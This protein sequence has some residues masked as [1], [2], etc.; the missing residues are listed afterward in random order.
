VL[1]WKVKEKLKESINKTLYAEQVL[2]SEN[3]YEKIVEKYGNKDNAKWA[4]DKLSNY[5][6]SKTTKYKSDYHVLIGWVF[7]EF[8]KKKLT[9]IKGGQPNAK[10]GTGH[11]GR[12]NAELDALSF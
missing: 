8:E 11:G 5:K 12:T 1:K 2:L 4:I 10:H 9:V 6:C 3:E 7:D